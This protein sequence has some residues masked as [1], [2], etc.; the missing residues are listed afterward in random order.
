MSTKKPVDHGGPP[1]DRVPPDDLIGTTTPALTNAASPEQNNNNYEDDDYEEADET[2]AT[3]VLKESFALRF[4]FRNSDTTAQSFRSNTTTI[5]I[6]KE[7][8]ALDLGIAITSRDKQLFI[9][10]IDEFPKTRK[11]FD[12]FFDVK[13]ENRPK[14]C[15]AYLRMWLDSTKRYTELKNHER[16]ISYLIKNKITMS[17]YDFREIT[18][19]V[20][21]TIIFRN[22]DTTN[23][24]DYE[25]TIRAIAM[26]TLQQMTHQERK[27][28]VLLRNIDMATFTLPQIRIFERRTLWATIPK[29][30]DAPKKS[31]STSVLEIVSSASDRKLLEL[32]LENYVD[33][34]FKTGDIITTTNRYEFKEQFYMAMQA[35]QMYIEETKTIRIFGANWTVLNG[36]M[37]GSADLEDTDKTVLDK[38]KE[39]TFLQNGS[40]RQL[41]QTVERTKD[42]EINGKIFLTFF[43]SQHQAVNEYLSDLPTWYSSSE[44]YL[45]H[46]PTIELPQLKQKSQPSSLFSSK[47]AA[48]GTD[49]PTFKNTKTL[50]NTPIRKPIFDI[51][52][53]THDPWT[54]S[55]SFAEVAA[56]P[57]KR[58]S[59]NDSDNDSDTDSTPRRL[60]PSKTRKPPNQQDQHS[61]ET[62]RNPPHSSNNQTDPNQVQNP[63]TPNDHPV[64]TATTTTT[65]TT[66]T[67]TA[68]NTNTNTFQPPPTEYPRLN[69]PHNKTARRQQL[70]P[71]NQTDSATRFKILEDRSKAQREALDR[72]SAMIAKPPPAHPLT[73]D[74][75]FIAL[76]DQQ[77]QMGQMMQAVCHVVMLLASSDPRLA[78]DARMLSLLST[79]FGEVTSPT[80]TPA[81]ES[82]PP[83]PTPAPPPAKPAP[84]P[85]EAWQTVARKSATQKPNHNS[86]QRTTT[87]PTPDHTT[88]TTPTQHQRHP[89]PPATPPKNQ[90]NSINPP[91]EKPTLRISEAL[92]SGH[93]TKETLPNLQLTTTDKAKQHRTH[94]G[95][96]AQIT[97]PP[98]SPPPSPTKLNDNDDDQDLHPP[99][100]SLPIP[101]ANT[102]D[103]DDDLTDADD[104]NQQELSDDDDYKQAASDSDDSSQP[105]ITILQRAPHQPIPDGVLTRQTRRQSGPSQSSKPLVPKETPKPPTAK[106]STS[107]K[108]KQQPTI[109]KAAANSGKKTR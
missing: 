55:A 8:F 44:H 52:A 2:A 29:L 21:G 58:K 101:E 36:K 50:K 22:P 82:T 34:T 89:V 9:N 72:L 99:L 17:L 98:N 74:P 70:P 59:R 27:S 11:D 73:Q 100:A 79:T 68:S 38:I 102:D 95:I 5:S 92:P 54:R 77:L 24:N 51:A 84:N 35:H 80:E 106:M 86:D 39:Q 71:N 23:R 33:T 1:D 85:P 62:N 31:F 28:H 76:R 42:T 83:S 6:L 96:A 25:D 78:N 48:F 97:A 61:N 109:G 20:V 60:P 4:E 16:M 67:A 90:K 18:T 64:P 30:D 65:T 37:I 3:P 91:A 15:T 88:P 93:S 81:S 108:P 41:I 19:A 103:D 40:P 32:L 49:E 13:I 87:Q 105:D 45:S 46:M 14:Q 56:G 104:M 63:S 12:R 10:S 57:N 43:S 75:S 107:R 66:A 94:H 26:L 69:L 47:I 53:T 7:L